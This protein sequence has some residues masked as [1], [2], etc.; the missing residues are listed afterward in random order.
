MTFSFIKM[1]GLTSVKEA[2]N[3]INEGYEADVSK[4]MDKHGIDHH[5]SG[6][7]LHV[8]KKDHAHAEK[9][10]TKKYGGYGPRGAK[11]MPQVHVKK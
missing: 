10:L 11:M 1:P 8:D 6:G 5:W 3:K 4:F 2:Q 9:K 7:K